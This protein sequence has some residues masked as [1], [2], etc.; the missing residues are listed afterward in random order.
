MVAER[1]VAQVLDFVHLGVAQPLAAELELRLVVLH[2]VG[3][4]P[5]ARLV[6]EMHVDVPAAVQQPHVDLLVVGRIGQFG[7]G[8]LGR[9]VDRRGDRHGRLA[10]ERKP[11]RNP[12]HRK[13]LGLEVPHQQAVVGDDV[14]IGRAADAKHLGAVGRDGQAH[15]AHVHRQP[16]GVRVLGQLHAAL[17]RQRV[18]HRQ[19]RIAAKRQHL[20]GRRE[21]DRQDFPVG[22]THGLVDRLSA[23][24]GLDGQLAVD[25]HSRQP[26]QF[27]RAAGRQRVTVFVDH[28]GQSGVGDLHADRFRRTE[29]GPQEHGGRIDAD[30]QLVRQLRE[31][32]VA[33]D[34]DEPG[35]RERARVGVLDLAEVVVQELAETVLRSPRAGRTRTRPAP[36]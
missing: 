17:D 32:D 13:R 6:H 5:L 27:R 19:G 21:L 15:L 11:D 23:L 34:V 14:E 26:D 2:R 12:Q 8:E 7:F 28:R 20:L 36:P 3:V 25:P 9:R 24:I 22:Q 4:D 33:G 16:L 1:V 29:V 18:G 30:R 10:Q 35:D 31:P